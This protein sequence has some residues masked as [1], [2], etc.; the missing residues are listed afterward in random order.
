MSSMSLSLLSYKLKIDNREKDLIKN[1]QSLKEKNDHFKDISYEIVMLPI[2][3]V[4]IEDK[5]GKE[6]IIIERKTISDLHASIRDGRYEEQS[7]RLNSVD[8][9]NHNIIYLIEGTLGEI[10]IPQYKNKTDKTTFFSSIFSLNYYKG[11]SVIRTNNLEETGFFICNTIIKLSKEKDRVGYYI[12]IE[13]KNGGEKNEDND[14]NDNENNNDDN[15]KNSKDYVDVL[16]RVKKEN[17]NMSNI[18]EIMLCQVPGI[19]S[20]TSKAIIKHYENISNFLLK[21][22]ENPEQLKEV[23][24]KNEKGQTKHLNKKCIEN[25]IKFFVT[26]V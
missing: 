19:S 15:D 2:G 25:L 17:I 22:R 7:Y 23:V 14:K 12:D 6:I 5:N 20:I 11:F 10:H 26:G 18:G 24:Y 13:K 4:I 9:P 3:D 16:K 1:I 8:L 21:I